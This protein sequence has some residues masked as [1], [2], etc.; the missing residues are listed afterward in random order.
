MN[1]SAPGF[2]RSAPL[3]L[4]GPVGL[5]SW[6]Q[7]LMQL[8]PGI[9]PQNY[10]LHL[11]ELAEERFEL[12]DIR[13]STCL[14]GHTPHSLS[15]RFD[16]PQGSLVYTGDCVTNPALEKLRVRGRSFGLR[17]LVPAGLAHRR[18][19]DRRDSWPAGCPGA[20]EAA[21]RHPPLPARRRRGFADPNWP[22]L[23]RS[24]DHRSGWGDFFAA[25]N[26]FPARPFG[27]RN[28]KGLELRKVWN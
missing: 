10:P 26:E 25:M 15:Y 5:R 17:M 12:G 16:T 11:R 2:V 6:Y 7:G 24:G 21:G 22:V 18:P 13:V 23:H 1:D 3:Y 27:F 9:S 28:P 19:Y 14:S 20:G 4:T 8:Y